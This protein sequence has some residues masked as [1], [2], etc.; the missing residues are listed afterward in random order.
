M[1]GA[2]DMHGSVEI[3]QTLYHA[4]C[5]LEWGSESEGL[6]ACWVRTNEGD[7]MGLGTLG[8]FV[9]DKRSNVQARGYIVKCAPKLG[10]EVV[11]C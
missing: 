6:R 11:S 9:F 10:P 4:P 8:S 2:L 1:M 5:T 7:S 3:Q